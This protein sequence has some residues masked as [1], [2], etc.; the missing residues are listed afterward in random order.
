MEQ[1]VFMLHR[2]S[3]HSQTARRNEAVQFSTALAKRAFVAFEVVVITEV[4]AFENALN[5]HSAG[6][7]DRGE[8]R[9]YRNDPTAV[10]TDA[11]R[12]AGKASTCGSGRNEQKH[13]FI[14]DEALHIA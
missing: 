4:G 10:I 3:K 2:R 8:Y 11:L 1:S 6:F 14:G 12:S 13:I 7:G 9:A 5:G